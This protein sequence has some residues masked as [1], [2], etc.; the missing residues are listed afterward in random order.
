MLQEHKEPLGIVVLQR[1][2]NNGISKYCFQDVTCINSF[3]PHNNFLL[4]EKEAM[5][6]RD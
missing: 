1:R 2:N 5:A 3:I 4:I 6:Q